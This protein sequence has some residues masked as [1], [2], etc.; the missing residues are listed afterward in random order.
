MPPLIAETA[1]LRLRHLAETDAAFMLA[2]LN[3]P[4]FHEHI[5]DRGVR[6][7]EQARDY[8]RDAP[9]ASYAR[10]GYGLYAVERQDGEL[11]GICGLVKRDA[12]PEPDIG[13][14]FLAAHEGQGY[15]R[16]AAQA[17]LDHARGVLG[18]ANVLAI[19]TPA[20][21][22]SIRL[23]EK[24]GLQFQHN[25]RLSDDN[26]ELRLFAIRFAVPTIPREPI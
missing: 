18:L 9:I 6:T 2:L 26:E 10:H 14:A 8:L 23:L 12:L 5:G 25:L 3:E 17:V 15:A 16:E 24:L 13:F 21:A 19:V 1:R 4:A 7:P 22:R 11:I 20:N